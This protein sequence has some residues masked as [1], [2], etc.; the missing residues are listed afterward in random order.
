MDFILI[1]SSVDCNFCRCGKKA[2]HKE[3]KA[4]TDKG[5]N[6]E[7]RSSWKMGRDA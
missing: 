5:G 3:T 6:V 2:L 4:T 1:K 7:N